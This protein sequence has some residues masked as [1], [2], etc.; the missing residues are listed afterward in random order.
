MKTDAKLQRDVVDELHADPRIEAA[1]IGVTA[2][3]GIVT[4]T[5]H[6]PVYAQKFFA[7]EAA[8][9]VHGVKAVAND[10]DVV[11]S[12]AGR[13]LDA[14]IAGAV[15]NALRLDAEIPDERLQV[16]VRDGWITVGGTVDWQFQKEAVDR[17]I[18]PMVGAR[19][20]TNTIVVQ[21][22]VEP[23]EAESVRGA[24]SPNA[25]TR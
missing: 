8:K 5:G 11:L 18:R 21:P 15:V 19:G 20:L 10:I 9:R 14:D 16:T 24:V 22:P 17:A 6:V 12:D 4:L 23:A 7:E 3:G 25:L 2:A 1:R 13:R